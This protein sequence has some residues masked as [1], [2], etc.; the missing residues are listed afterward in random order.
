MQV[1]ET[2]PTKEEVIQQLEDGKSVKMG[3]FTEI[4]DDFTDEHMLQSLDELRLEY[5]KELRQS[6]RVF[7]TKI[8]KRKSFW[9]ISARFIKDS[10]LHEQAPVMNP[11]LSFVEAYY[12]AKGQGYKYFW[13]N[14]NLYSAEK[15]SN[16]P[17][18][19]P[20]KYITGF[21]ELPEWLLDDG[22]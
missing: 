15:L 17:I 8:E 16:I 18:V 20:T 5:E 19:E 13:W 3:Y 12:A 11:L 22:A 14:D 2:K 10:T 4:P 9:A 7:E 6:I 1:W 21:R